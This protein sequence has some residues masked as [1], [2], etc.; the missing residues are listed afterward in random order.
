MIA[1]LGLIAPGFAYGE[2][3][4]EDV[5][6]AFGYVPAGLQTLSSFFS[7]PLSGYT[8][9]LPFLNGANAALWQAGVGYEIAGIVGI[10]LIGAAILILGR[11]LGR[12]GDPA[13]DIAGS[14]PA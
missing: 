3:G 9:P 10:L 6:Q 2:G 12:G 8:I 13:E 1:P 7:A 11:V 14:A 5:Q 4:P